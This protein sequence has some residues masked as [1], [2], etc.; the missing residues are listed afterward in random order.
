MLQ[1]E[2]LE[3]YRRFS[4]R[5]HWTA[6]PLTADELA[7]YWQRFE[8]LDYYTATRSR[9]F[10]EARTAQ[11]LRAFQTYAWN[12]SDGEQYALAL[13]YQTPRAV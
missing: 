12:V 9:M 2:A 1:R 7:A 3:G 11:E 4:E 10:W 13:T 5:N 6:G 8:A